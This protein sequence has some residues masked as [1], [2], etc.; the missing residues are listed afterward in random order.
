MSLAEVRGPRRKMADASR[1]KA[2]AC[3]TTRAL[4]ERIAQ[5]PY[6]KHTILIHP[7][8]VR[9]GEKVRRP[10]RFSISRKLAATLRKLVS[11]TQGP[12][13]GPDRKA[14]NIAAYDRF[15]QGRKRAGK[16]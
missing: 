10:A 13:S 2:G 4:Q 3:P 12:K 5:W 7:G 8:E 16:E 1:L 6:S 11:G 15:Y 9:G 14:A